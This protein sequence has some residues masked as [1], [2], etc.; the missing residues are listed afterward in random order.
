MARKLEVQLKEWTHL[1]LEAY[2]NYDSLNTI[3]IVKSSGSPLRILGQEEHVKEICNVLDIFVK[4]NYLIPRNE[5]EVVYFGTKF[6]SYEYVPTKEFKQLLNDSQK[7]ENIN[8][9]NVT[10]INITN[11]NNTNKTYTFS[12]NFIVDKIIEL[13]ASLLSIF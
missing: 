5:T 6:K 3:E 10:V 9:P 12:M 4:L 13:K 7:S 1:V 2:I 8:V 11:Q